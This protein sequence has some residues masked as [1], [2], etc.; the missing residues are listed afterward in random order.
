MICASPL[1][2][3]VD[4]KGV[5]QLN[6]DVCS[7][8]RTCVLTLSSTRRTRRAGM[9]AIKAVASGWWLVACNRKSALPGPSKRGGGAAFRE[10]LRRVGAFERLE[11]IRDSTAKKT[12]VHSA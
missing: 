3:Q 11:R 6:I 4:T 7:S 10:Q 9:R 5:F 2:I 12:V 1:K 8:M